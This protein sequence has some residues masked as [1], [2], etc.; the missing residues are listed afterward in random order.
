MPQVTI[1]DL[2][3]ETTAEPTKAEAPPRQ[4]GGLTVGAPGGAGVEPGQR[5]LHLMAQH[6][7]G[8]GRLPRRPVGGPG[9][10]LLHPVA[11]LL[12]PGGQRPGLFL[13]SQTAQLPLRPAQGVAP[14]GDH[15]L[16][17]RVGR[18]QISQGE[19]EPPGWRTR[20]RP[21]DHRRCPPL[22]HRGEP[23]G[24]SPPGRAGGDAA[25]SP[26]PRTPP[27]R[28]PPR[29]PARSAAEAP[30]AGEP[31]EASPPRSGGGEDRRGALPA[32]RPGPA[33]PGRPGA[34]P[35]GAR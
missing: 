22:R 28:P 8:E 12:L 10:L 25:R 32:G 19:E 17:R 2:S 16:H 9:L 27:H 21:G 3:A 11:Q 18:R 26:G 15:L 24:R 14:P 29:G 7:Q 31:G 4:R 5:P 20:P 34:R 35:A 6:P 23:P 30:P 33:F 13:G 1:L